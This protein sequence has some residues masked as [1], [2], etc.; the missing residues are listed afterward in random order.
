MAVTLTSSGIRFP[1]NSEQTVPKGFTI[2]TP[3]TTNGQS[4]VTF[5]GIP[6]YAQ[7]IVVNIDV[8]NSSGG[9]V[10]TTLSFKSNNDTSFYSI[11]S[12]AVAKA[13]PGGSGT[14]HYG[15]F[16]G[17]ANYLSLS[18]SSRLILE[19][20][21]AAPGGIPHYY[22]E[23]YSGTN[24]LMCVGSLYNTS[25]T[26]IDTIRIGYTSG[27]TWLNPKIGITWE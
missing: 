20:I 6:T 23:L 14:F 19:Y 16:G 1:D 3:F 13:S 25:N 11:N 8:G 9:P 21:S 22:V 27:Y 4:T 7:K 2:G 17:F 26:R 15:P 5:T 18:T 24:H 10:G 12:V